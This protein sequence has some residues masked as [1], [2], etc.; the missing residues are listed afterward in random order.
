MPF[1]H[2]PRSLIAP[3]RHFD[4]ELNCMGVSVSTL[5]SAE[6]LEDPFQL[7]AVIAPLCVAPG[8]SCI[9]QTLW[10]GL[11]VEAQN[12]AFPRSPAEKLLRR[13]LPHLQHPAPG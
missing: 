10:R 8:R 11:F 9:S 13:S 3:A 2:G 4:E 5:P 6:P 7:F 1:M 12:L